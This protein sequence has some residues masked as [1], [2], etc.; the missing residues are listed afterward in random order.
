M[1]EVQEVK[2]LVK[3]PRGRPRKIQTSPETPP[4]QPTLIKKRGRPPKVAQSCV[5][6]TIKLYKSERPEEYYVVSI[7]DILFWSQTTERDLFKQAAADYAK[8]KKSKA[9]PQIRWYKDRI[10]VVS[11]K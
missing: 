9:N 8:M 2:A 4:P 3:R 1:V 5:K 6:T 10:E 7:D 11:S